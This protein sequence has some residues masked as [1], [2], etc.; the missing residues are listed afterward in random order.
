MSAIFVTA[1]GT[2]IGKTFVTAGLIRHLRSA[3]K[4]VDA[5]KPV[6]S[7]FDPAEA[8]GS[9]PGILLGCARTPSERRRDRA[10]RT[11]AFRGLSRTRPCGPAREP[12]ARFRALLDFSRRAIAAHS[13]TLL[14][15]GVGGIMVPVDDSHTVL[16]WMTALQPA[17]RPG[18]RQLSRHHQPHADRARC[19]SPSWTFDQG[20]G[21]QRNA[22]RHGDARGHGR[23]PVTLR[24][25]TCRS[26][27]C[28]GFRPERQSMP[29]SER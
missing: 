7:G 29:R 1:T 16:D 9:D 15:E 4:A 23:E 8:E 13:G 28:P 5:L 18:H 3:G 25:R 6:V 19:A 14:I 26:C 27:P 2:D 17:A 22:G 20:A 21:G 10:D 12:H 24:G 11:L